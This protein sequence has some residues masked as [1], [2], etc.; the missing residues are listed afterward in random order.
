MATAFR[1][2]TDTVLRLRLLQCVPASSHRLI[3]LRRHL[4][5]ACFFQ[6]IGYLSALADDAIDLKGIARHLERPQY[7]TSNTTDYGELAAAI[8]I[9]GIAIDCG[10]PPSSPCATREDKSFNRDIDVLSLKVKSMF[11]NIVD[12]G[13]SHMGRTDAKEVLEAFQYLLSYGVRMKP[14]PKK[15][16]FEDST[17]EGADDKYMMEAFVERGKQNHSMP[18]RTACKDRAI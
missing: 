1:S 4:A 13:A 14:P 5:L 7:V 11:A 18:R 3:F 6:D 8:A 17:V 12:M 10:D 16:L 2:I 15:P 9:L